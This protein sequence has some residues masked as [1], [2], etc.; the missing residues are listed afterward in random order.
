M[1]HLSEHA[2]EAMADDEITEEEIAECLEHGELEIKQRIRGEL[3]WGRKLNLKEK[4]IY[5]YLH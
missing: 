5:G 2:R 3:R 1:I 4:T